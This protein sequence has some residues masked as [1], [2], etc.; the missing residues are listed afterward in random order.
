MSK[1]YEELEAELYIA[2]AARDGILKTLHV[3]HDLLLEEKPIQALNVLNRGLAR[4][5]VK[6]GGKDE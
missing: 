6:E 1:E 2:Q 5:E 3:V 4:Y